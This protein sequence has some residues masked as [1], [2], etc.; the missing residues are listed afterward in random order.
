LVAGDDVRALRDAIRRVLEDA[1][2]AHRLVENGR[3]A[4]ESGYTR[5]A[6]VRSAMALYDKIKVAA[7]AGH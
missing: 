7:A 4:Y 5:Q 1:E 2:T 6:F 3:R